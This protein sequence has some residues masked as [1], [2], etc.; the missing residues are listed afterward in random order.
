M[1]GDTPQASLHLYE[2][3]VRDELKLWLKTH[4]ELDN[5]VELDSGNP[6]ELGQEY[7]QLFK[8]LPGLCVLGGC[9]GTDHRHVEA[10]RGA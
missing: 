5:C 8:Q 9:C 1:G 7:Q 6:I 2:K 4:G 10:I 3:D